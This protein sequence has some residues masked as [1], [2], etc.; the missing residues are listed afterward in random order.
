[1]VASAE[2]RRQ[3]HW[4][5]AVTAGSA[6]LQLASF[7]LRRPPSWDEAIYLS[8]VSRGVPALPFVASRARG[9][10]MLVAPLTSVG[11]PLWLVRLFLMIVSALV[12]GASFRLWVPVVGWGAPIGAFLFAVSWPAAFYGSE[13]MPNLW[14][15]FAC[16]ACL[17]FVA[18]ALINGSHPFRSSGRWGAGLCACA[19]ALIRPPDAAVL[20]IAVVAALIA[21]AREG[22]R[23][24]SAV[25]VGALVG[26]LPWLV[27]MSVRF[28]GPL[29]AVREA[30][31]VAHLRAG[32]GLGANVALTDGPLLGPDPTGALPWVGILWWVGLV[33]LTMVA[34]TGSRGGTARTGLRVT[35]VA[36]VALALEYIVLIGGLAPRFL[37]PALGVLSLGAGAGIA[38][39]AVG[40][41]EGRTAGRVAALATVV[42]IAAWMSWQVATARRLEAAAST[43]RAVPQS[44][45]LAIARTIGDESCVVASTDDYPQVALA[46]RCRGRL[47]TGGGL[48]VSSP[49]DPDRATIVVARDGPLPSG[50]PVPGLPEGWFAARG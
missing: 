10:T 34:C 45:G 16:V 4:V 39:V 47:A 29:E 6:V 26:A 2:L 50:T 7:S 28:G 33:A 27:E 19:C 46:A 38:R 36:G 5:W 37:L 24:G 43:E 32:G 48:E 23:I 31:D 41:A 49:P 40:R 12:L 30:R 25:A 8:Q 21:F 20:A 44:V 22:W 35:A 42:A 13:V 15:A 14:A 3:R 18:R 1:M 11:A 9:I 17:G